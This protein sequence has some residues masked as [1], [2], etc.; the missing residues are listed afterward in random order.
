MASST[1]PAEERTSPDA[2]EPEAGTLAPGLPYADCAALRAAAASGGA[3]CTI[4]GIEGSFSRQLGAQL[5]IRPDGT[6]VGS[7]ADGCLESQ[8]AREAS[9][10]ATP[11]VRHFGRG[12]NIVDFRLPCGSALHILI[13]P[14]PDRRQLAATVQDLTVRKAA[15]V[16]LPLPSDSPP[17][18][19]GRRH[20]LPAL[21]IT[22]LGT[23]PELAIFAHLARAAGIDIDTHA[24]AGRT[25]ALGR[26]PDLP[27][28]DRWTAV[29]LLFHDHEWER[30]ALRWALRGDAFYIGAQ[31]G[32]LARQ[33]RLDDLRASG[34]ADAEL[35]RI[36]SPVGLFAKA[37]N[38]NSLALSALG[39][40]VARYDRLHAAS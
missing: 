12:S 3:L 25:L 38:P 2:D 33:R 19:L 17:G 26:A 40:I 29:L 6:M 10:C 23:D 20:Y 13:D 39:E 35:A 1:A 30:D 14:A 15:T 16:D 5:A 11:V 28:P 32:A 36:T 24:P 37:R 21:R 4:V 22:A 8:L 31:G 9:R 7:L 27:F 34:I 18:L